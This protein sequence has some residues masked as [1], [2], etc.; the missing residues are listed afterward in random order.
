[1]PGPIAEVVGKLLH[2]MKGKPVEAKS[3]EVGTWNKTTDTCVAGPISLSS[4]LC[5]AVYGAWLPARCMNRPSAGE[6]QGFGGR[7]GA[8]QSAA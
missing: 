3:D 7:D 1:M 2:P 4:H 8:G 5:L 6:T